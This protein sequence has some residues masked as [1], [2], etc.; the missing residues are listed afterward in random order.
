MLNRLDRARDDNSLSDN[1]GKQAER[2]VL[3]TLSRENLTENRN[4]AT[5]FANKIRN[6]LGK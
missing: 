5:T 3:I 6:D 4:W 2:L 1:S